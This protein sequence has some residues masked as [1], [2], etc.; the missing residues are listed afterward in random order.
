MSPRKPSNRPLKESI[1]EEVPALT[2]N[3]VI[4]DD[5]DT[6]DPINVRVV[7]EAL[8]IMGLKVAKVST[9]LWWGSSFCS[10]PLE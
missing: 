5:A 2:R 8:Q 6:T 10:I 1:F 9:R 7:L 4:E 3:S